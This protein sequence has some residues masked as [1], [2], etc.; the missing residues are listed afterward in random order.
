MRPLRLA[1]VGT[2]HLG[3]FH[4]R[5]LAG[6]PQTEL[7]AVVD[8]NADRAHGVATQY[9]AVALADVDQLAG[10]VDAVVLA[11]PTV[12]HHAVTLRLLSQGL[13]VLVEK[14]LAVDSRQA[15]EMVSAAAAAGRILQV[16]HVERFNPAL[17]A[18]MP[19]I[20]EPKYIDAVRTSGYTFRSTDIG[21]VLDLMIHDIDLALAL[22]RCGVERVDALGVAVFG[23]HEDVANARLVFEN[24]CV[25]NLSASRASYQAIRRMHVW[26]T[27]GFCAMDFA[28]RQATL[29]RPS[30]A[31]MQRS[32]DPHSLSPEEQQQMKERLFEDHLARQ[33]LTAEPIDQLT[34]ELEDFTDSIRQ[35]RSPRVSGGQGSEAVIV[36]EQILTEI[37]RHHWN[38]QKPGPVGPLLTTPP[39]VIPAPHWVRQPEAPTRHKQAG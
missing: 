13:H 9:G 33:S 25:A 12:T 23:Q 21:V 6:M 31:I 11:T 39:A 7:V 2:G 24:G 5:I 29:V 26:G 4:A 17:T 27:S 20:R 22:N 18:A 28:S 37:E 15:R 8:A 34:A 1:V 36:A 38:G 19:G 14:P 10:R 32:L 16:G 35:N 3:Q 30:E